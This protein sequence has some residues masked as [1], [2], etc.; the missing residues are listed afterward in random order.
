MCSPR[1][2]RRKPSS[3]RIQ[4]SF[5]RL[6]MKEKNLSLMEP[7]GLNHQLSPR[8]AHETPGLEEEK[9]RRCEEGEEGERVRRAGGYCRLQLVPADGPNEPAALLSQEIIKTGAVKKPEPGERMET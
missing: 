5:K 2:A 1:D 7:D 9:S 6:Q 8:R 3:E 4:R